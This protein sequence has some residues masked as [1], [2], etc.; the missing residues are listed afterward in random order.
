M[1]EYTAQRDG[2]DLKKRDQQKFREANIL[3]PE[4]E[5][6]LQQWMFN[7]FGLFIKIDHEKIQP[8][9]SFIVVN[10]QDDLYTMHIPDLNMIIFNGEKSLR[11]GTHIGEEVSHCIRSK[12][13]DENDSEEEMTDEFFGYLGR[14][15]MYQYMTIF[16]NNLCGH[17]FPNGPPSLE[18]DTLP[19]K[20]ILKLIKRMRQ[21]LAE[22]HGGSSDA[23]PINKEGME[24]EFRMR[25]LLAHTRG[26]QFAAKIDL[27]QIKNWEA[28]YR[29]SNKEIRRRFFTDKPDYSGL[30]NQ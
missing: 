25:S 3:K 1:S 18:K 19:V 7:G 28:L 20:E 5:K 17:F 9:P 16:P 10:E 22:I 26:Y 11:S 13:Q 24:I 29:M 12:L 14:C 30:S 8:P 15:L 27:N 6:E 2:D 4:S 21:K 23:C